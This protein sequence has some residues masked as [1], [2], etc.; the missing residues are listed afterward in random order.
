VAERDLFKMALGLGEPWTVTRADFDPG[1]GRLDVW[2]DFPRGSRFPCPAA[3]CA[4]LAGKL[5][6]PSLSGTHTM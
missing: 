5:P 4:L 2:L 1:E 3:G 6:K